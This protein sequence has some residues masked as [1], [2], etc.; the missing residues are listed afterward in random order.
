[1]GMFSS[2]VAF[3][4]A[5]PPSGV[6]LNPRFVEALMGLPDGMTDSTPLAMPSFRSWL[7]THSQRL[8]VLLD[9]TSMVRKAA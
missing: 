9:S 3:D 1:M 7:A 2:G 6:V 4:E 8:R 5:H